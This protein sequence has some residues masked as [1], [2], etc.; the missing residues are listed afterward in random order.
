MTFD[1]KDFADVTRALMSDYAADRLPRSL[2]NDVLRALDRAPI[3]KRP[4]WAMPLT[5]AAFFL[6]GLITLLALPREHRLPF[7]GV[8]PGGPQDP[9]RQRLEQLRREIAR[10]REEI[11]KLE[12]EIAQASSRP[13]P[14][15]RPAAV[16]S[17]IRVTAIALEIGLVVISAGEEDGVVEGG[18]FWIYRDGAVIGQMV[19]DRRDRKWSAGK[20]VSKILAP[21][22]GDS[23]A[24]SN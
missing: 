14:A 5:A 20:I 16:I 7:V 12:E 18:R 10:V 3:R 2:R 4:V 9:D 22:V 19:V 6:A 1:D 21:R 17:P 24:P 23:V 15:P 11:R 13:P 8:Q